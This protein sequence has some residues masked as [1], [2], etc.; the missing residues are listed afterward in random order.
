MTFEY[1]PGEEEIFLR[2]RVQGKTCESC[3]NPIF[4]STDFPTVPGQVYSEDGALEVDISGYCEHC[5][6]EITRVLEE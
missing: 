6:D 2:N 4:Y 3:L 1:V 5:F